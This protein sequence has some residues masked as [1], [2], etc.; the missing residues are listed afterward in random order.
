[1][2][3]LLEEAA[4]NNNNKD[5][6]RKRTM[7]IIK[8][9]T[10]EQS[11]MVWYGSNG[12]EEQQHS[13][14]QKWGGCQKALALSSP[15]F[16]SRTHGARYGREVRIVLVGGMVHQLRSKVSTRKRMSF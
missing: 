5:D 8:R 15:L 12:F 11:N 13:S 16:V 4:H 3:L 14:K 10:K 1:M 9:E 2:V 6:D 7:K